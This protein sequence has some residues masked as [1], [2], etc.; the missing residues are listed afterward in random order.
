MRLWLRFL[1]GTSVC[2]A[3]AGAATYLLIELREFLEEEFFSGRFPEFIHIIYALFSLMIALIMIRFTVA[4]S[5][6]ELSEIGKQKKER[7]KREKER[8]QRESDIE[9]S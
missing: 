9:D 2:F 1:G 5:L 7:K 8:K 4:K 3:L 6:A